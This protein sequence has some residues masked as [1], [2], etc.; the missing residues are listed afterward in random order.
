MRPKIEV[1]LQGTAV[2]ERDPKG[3]MFVMCPEGNMTWASSP[4]GASVLIDRWRKAMVL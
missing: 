3:G 1:I 2:V 4:R